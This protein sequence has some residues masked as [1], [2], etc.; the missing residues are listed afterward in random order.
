MNFAN[1]I[2]SLKCFL[3]RKFSEEIVQREIENVPFEV[4]EGNE[5]SVVF[6]VTW[7]CCLLLD[8]LVDDQLSDNIL[9]FLMECTPLPPLSFLQVD[10]QGQRILVT[11][12]QV[13][14][15]L[16]KR[17]SVF[18]EQHTNGL[19]SGVVVSVCS[20]CGF[21]LSNFMGMRM[22]QCVFAMCSALRTILIRNVVPSTTRAASR[23]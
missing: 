15:A 19:V 9:P 5:G 8:G 1:T 10:C 21:C 13:L 11:P 3:G 7:T 22:S 18:A 14:G 23:G 4:R 17:L 16:L 2:R 12:E 20:Y 6:E